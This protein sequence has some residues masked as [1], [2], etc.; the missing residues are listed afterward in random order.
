MFDTDRINKRLFLVN[1]GLGPGGAG[2][3]GGQANDGGAGGGGMN[4]AG[5]GRG[6]DARA[7]DRWGGEQKGWGSGK[8]SLSATENAAIEN[9]LKTFDQY[10]TARKAGPSTVSNIIGKTADGIIGMLGGPIVALANQVVLKGTTGNTLG[11]HATNAIHNSAL[12]GI[13]N[14]GDTLS[15]PIGGAQTG[16]SLSDKYGRDTQGTGRDYGID[17]PQVNSESPPA[18]TPGILSTT[19]EEIENYRITAA[20]RIQ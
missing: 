1:A 15:S 6:N 11:G 18:E 19:P 8:A 17:A 3:S 13:G 2:S 20:R 5:S 4:D 9:S 14:V 7:G 10:N 12:S 16:Q